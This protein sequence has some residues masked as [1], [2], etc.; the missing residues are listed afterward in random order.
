MKH[1]LFHDE[2]QEINRKTKIGT[3]KGNHRGVLKTSERFRAGCFYC[4][5]DGKPGCICGKLQGNFGVFSRGYRAAG[6]NL[7]D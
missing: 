6:K 7:P 2:K 5:C 4:D 3:A 1:I